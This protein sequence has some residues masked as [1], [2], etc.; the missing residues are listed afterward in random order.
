VLVA[1][2]R[3]ETAVG[4][5]EAVLKAIEDARWDFLQTT[6]RTASYYRELRRLPLVGRRL[7]DRRDRPE[8]AGR[9]D[10]P[11]L[12]G[13]GSPGTRPGPKPGENAV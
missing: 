5:D 7:A 12:V 2:L 13:L 3:G 4:V 11:Y 1:R 8:W 9:N 6:K 10:E